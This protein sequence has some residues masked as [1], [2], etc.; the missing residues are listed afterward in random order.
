MGRNHCL[1]STVYEAD[2]SSRTVRHWDTPESV[3]RAYLGGRGLNVYYL[4]KYLKPGTDALS[5]DNVLL[6]GP[7]LLTVMLRR[8]EGTRRKRLDMTLKAFCIP[9][10]IAS[11][12]PKNPSSIER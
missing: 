11:S 8:E 3:V 9:S 1:R 12:S 2:L 6:F 5:P 7:G 4:Y 10:S